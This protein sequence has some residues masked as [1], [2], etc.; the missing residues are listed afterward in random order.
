MPLQPLSGVRPKVIGKAERN[1][2]VDD[3]CKV[4]DQA[5]AKLDKNKD[6]LLDEREI[7]V[8]MKRLET[9]TRKMEQTVSG[10][11]SGS[12][13]KDSMQ[14]AFAES[15]KKMTDATRYDM[16]I[17][18]A[19]G[20]LGDSTADT[21]PVKVLQAAVRQVWEGHLKA[22]KQPK[23]GIEGGLA[24]MFAMILLPDAALKAAKG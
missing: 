22:I 2:I 8:F 1:K 6:G 9:T 20:N 21:V 5:I 14:K 23:D 10:A 17:A 16:A 13:N 7:K 4:T 19:A 15:R 12:A 24:M 18:Q 3:L 11:M